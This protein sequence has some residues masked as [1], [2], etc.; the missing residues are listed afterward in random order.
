MIRSRRLDLMAHSLLPILLAASLLAVSLFT[1]P[2]RAIAQVS[3]WTTPVVGSSWMRGNAIAIDVSGNSYVVGEFGDAPGTPAPVAPMISFGGTIPNINSIVGTVDAYLVKHNTNGVATRVHQ[4]RTT[5]IGSSVTATGIALQGNYAFVTGEVSGNVDFGVSGAP[6]PVPAPPRSS[7]VACIQISGASNVTTWVALITPAPNTP[8]LVRAKSIATAGGQVYVCGDMRGSIIANSAP[9]ISNT[10]NG[11]AATTSMFIAEYFAS[12]GISMR[13]TFAEPM[14]PT[15]ESSAM[16]IAATMPG[17]YSRAVAVG[18]FRGTVKWDNITRVGDPT[19]DNLLVA[20]IGTSGIDP[21]LSSAKRATQSPTGYIKGRGVA[22]NSIGDAYVTGEFGGMLEFHNSII[23]MSTASAQD[24]F[25]AKF[26]PGGSAQTSLPGGATISSRAFA[27]SITVDVDGSDNNIYVTGGLA[28]SVVQ[29][30]PNGTSVTSMGNHDVLTAKFLEGSPN[31]YTFKWARRDGNRRYGQNRNHHDVGTG[32]AIDAQRRAHIVGEFGGE[33]DPKGDAEFFRD[34]DISTDHFRNIFTT[35]Y[36]ED[37]NLV[38]GRVTYNGVA[39]ER[40]RIT[41]MLPYG[42]NTLD[43]DEVMTGAG[44]YFTAYAPL[45]SDYRVLSDASP[46]YTQSIPFNPNYYQQSSPINDANFTFVADTARGNADL[47]IEMVPMGTEYV[48]PGMTRC[49]RIFYKNE[50]AKTLLGGATITLNASSHLTNPT[51]TFQPPVTQGSTQLTWTI[52]GDIAPMAHGEIVVCFDFPAPGPLDPPIPEGTLITS[53]V[54]INAAQENPIYTGNNAAPSD[55][56]LIYPLDPNGKVSLPQGNLDVVEVRNTDEIEYMID[57]YNVGA[58]PV[59]EVDIDDTFDPLYFDMT[60]ARQMQLVQSSPGLPTIDPATPPLFEFRNANLLAMHESI[61][62][63]RGFVRFTVPLKTELTVG[64]IVTNTATVT[65]RG[66]R[67]LTTNTWTNCVAPGFSVEDLCLG[68]TTTFETSPSSGAGYLPT[69]A[70]N[71]KWQFGDGDSSIVANPTHVYATAGVYVVVLKFKSGDTI[72]G[73]APSDSIHTVTKQ[74]VVSPFPTIPT[75]AQSGDTLIA[76][77]AAS[78]QW[79]LNGS[80]I[81]PNGTNRTYVVTTAG[82]Y[83]VLVANGGGCEALSVSVFV[84]PGT[85]AITGTDAELAFTVSPNPSRSQV[86]INAGT[87]ASMRIAIDIVNANGTL[88]ASG[89]IERGSSSCNFDLSDRP[90]GAYSAVLDIGGHKVTR[91][92]II[93][94]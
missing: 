81:T 78:Y 89:V 94:R 90:S 79:F 20:N 85:G 82:N 29:G 11:T 41:L 50:G 36:S 8:D 65:F 43:S 34:P 76:D 88:V 61:S 87:P 15:S 58:G 4:F 55:D 77:S 40:H 54:E 63:S 92:F 73:F 19:F 25:I 69:N 60:G 59:D 31:V 71:I 93:Y 74:I 10:T 42:S 45:S 51:S 1:L 46:H 14:T 18:S 72:C 38:R 56:E 62:G 75:I 86:T 35:K 9:G 30:G 80:P 52:P 13:L 28:G 84:T 3:V 26:A 67:T 17:S 23:T 53:I 83:S 22:F 91:R 33:M 12:N 7:Y 5:S 64:T 39:D 49:Y 66:Q 37:A 2:S 24:Y 16:S 47:S 6:Y 32:I 70:T 68:E 21:W 48:V 27:N 44:G 57:F